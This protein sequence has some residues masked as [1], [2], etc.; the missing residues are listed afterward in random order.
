M[1]KLA[2][3]KMKLVRMTNEIYLDRRDDCELSEVEYR[4]HFS[5]MGETIFKIDSYESLTDLLKDLTIEN[6]GHIGI[7]DDESVEELLEEVFGR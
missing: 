3:L 4:A 6:F 2:K 5:N 7:F 1:T